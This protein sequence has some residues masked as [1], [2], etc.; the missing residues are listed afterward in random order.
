MNGQS[1][2]DTYTDRQKESKTENEKKNTNY[3]LGYRI[4]VSFLITYLKT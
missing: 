2:P 1:W 4:E 3:V